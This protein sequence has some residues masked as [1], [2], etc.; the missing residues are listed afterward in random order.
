MSVSGFETTATG[1][2]VTTQWRHC[3]RRSSLWLLSPASGAFFLVPVAIVVCAGGTGVF[4]LCA[5]VGGFTLPLRAHA[6]VLQTLPCPL[7]N[8]VGGALFFPAKDVAVVV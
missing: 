2:A 3:W 7:D 1:D 5:S 6:G 4:W 8:L